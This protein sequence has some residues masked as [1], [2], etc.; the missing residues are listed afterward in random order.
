[1]DKKLGKKEKKHLKGIGDSFK[2]RPSF[3]DR[4][5]NALGFDKEE[6]KKPKD[7]E[8]KE[9]KPYRYSKPVKKRKVVNE[10]KAKKFSLFGE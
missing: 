1:M 8:S 7:K 6:E 4:V 5:K 2:D 3:G 9:K 10:K